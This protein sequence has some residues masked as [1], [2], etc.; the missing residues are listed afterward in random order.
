MGGSPGDQYAQQVSELKGADP[1]GLL[2]QVKALKQAYQFAGISPATVELV[3]AHG[4]GTK[5]GDAI[6]LAA[7]D[8]VYRAVAAAGSWCRASSRSRSDTPGLAVPRGML[9]YR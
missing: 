4:T 6:E 8:E 7:L 5:V 9:P 3:E 1:G 2:R